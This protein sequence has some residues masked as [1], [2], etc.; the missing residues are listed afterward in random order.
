MMK[1]MKM[2]MK[3]LKMMMLFQK[4]ILVGEKLAMEWMQVEWIDLMNKRESHLIQ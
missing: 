4:K 3:W 2:M 1:M